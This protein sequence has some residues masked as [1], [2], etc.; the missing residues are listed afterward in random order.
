M[1]GAHFGARL[2]A[3]AGK[4]G[5]TA[6][7]FTADLPDKTRRSFTMTTHHSIQRTRSAGNPL[8]G[9]ANIRP[10]Y[11]NTHAECAGNQ[12]VAFV[13][14]GRLVVGLSDGKSPP[15]E[16]QPVCR[17]R[18]CLLLID[19]SSSMSGGNLQQAKAGG[20]GFSEQALAKEYAVGVIRFACD[21]DLVCS[22]SRDIQRIRGPLAALDASG[23]TNMTA[24][25]DLA[26]TH[27][28]T[29]QPMQAIVLATDGMPDNPASTLSAARKAKEEGIQIIVIGTDDADSAFLR[30]CE[31]RSKSAAGGGAE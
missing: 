29:R 23:S 9:C 11:Q 30:T 24:A 18:K 20:L 17:D 3:K 10:T 28:A 15:V 14:D 26:R 16:Y 19:C 4:T 2:T 6:L 8:T 13:R 22:P 25:I 12:L 21:A 5:P 1:L 31:G 7:T 27:L